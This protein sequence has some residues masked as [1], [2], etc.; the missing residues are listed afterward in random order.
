MSCWFV[1]WSEGLGS[2]VWCGGCVVRVAVLVGCV[3]CRK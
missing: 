2:G 3:W 1:E